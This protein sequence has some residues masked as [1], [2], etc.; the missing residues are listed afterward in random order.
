MDDA[1][2]GLTSLLSWSTD[3]NGS[4]Y[5]LAGSI[6]AALLG[7]ALIFVVWALAT[8][9]ENAKS[10]LIAWLVCVIFTLLFII[11]K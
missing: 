10:Y 8:K 6:A 1:T 9:K 5:N 11:N 2:Q 7:V 4:A 3:F